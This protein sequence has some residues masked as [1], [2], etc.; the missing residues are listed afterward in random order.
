MAAV[1]KLII[2]KLGGSLITDKS[3]PLTAKEQVIRRLGKEI[4]SASRRY[5][6]K[7][8]IGHGSGSFGHFLATKF[9]THK[10]IINDKSLEG[11]AKVSDVAAKLNRIVAKN[12]LK[13]GLNVVSFS[14]G[15]FIVSRSQ[16]PQKY[17]LEPIKEALKKGVIPLIHGDV[18]FDR[19]KGFGIFSTEEVIKIIAGGLSKEYKIERIIFTTIT[20]G[21]YDKEGSTIPKI[22]SVNF[23]MF[24]SD[25]RGALGADVTGGMIQKVRKSLEL[26]KKYKVAV[27]I[28]N[29]RIKAN[30]KMAILG[31]NAGGTL[32]N[33]I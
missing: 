16:K 1:Q 23:K 15:S 17:F 3:K 22:T 32:I 7:I 13:V 31:E 25:I 6:G 20:N 24:E 19:D 11:A 8:I 26:S 21:V 28:I 4:L 2:I 9:Q 14:P 33:Y 5:Q 30:I 29:G 12:F 10:G 27:S 18:V